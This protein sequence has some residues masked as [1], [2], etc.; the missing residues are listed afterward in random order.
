MEE[1]GDFNLRLCDD[2]EMK[3]QEQSVETINF[4]NVIMTW[5]MRNPGNLENLSMKTILDSFKWN[6]KARI[7]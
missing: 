2:N 3:P 1:V 5:E 6:N 4:I 7:P